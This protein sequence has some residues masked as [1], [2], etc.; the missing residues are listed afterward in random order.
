M[1]Q[2]KKEMIKL[3]YYLKSL[4]KD[5]VRQ[6]EKFRALGKHT[7]D[8]DMRM[9]KSERLA[10]R[11]QDEIFGSWKMLRFAI[12]RAHP[13]MLHS[14]K[15]IGREYSGHALDAGQAWK[16]PGSQHVRD[17]TPELFREREV[18][19]G[20]IRDDLYTLDQLAAM[21]S[22]Y[23]KRYGAH[24]HLISD[25][26]FK[27]VQFVG[28]LVIGAGLTLLGQWVASLLGIDQ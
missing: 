22:E 11:A 21:A 18:L 26:A 23:E 9:N 8:V 2:T 10:K 14:M 1:E 5:M 6:I 4:N 19:E 16:Y 7:V 20:D 24:P 17:E 15:D 13:R 3:L 12:G 25:R 27:W 28:G